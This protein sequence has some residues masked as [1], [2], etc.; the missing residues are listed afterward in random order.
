MDPVP[1]GGREARAQGSRP[2]VGRG[3]SSD[4]EAEAAVLGVSVHR[5][6]QRG[7]T[8]DP[9]QPRRLSGDRLSAPC[10]PRSPSQRPPNHGAGPRAVDAGGDLAR[11]VH[12]HRPSRGGAGGRA[13]C[14]G[15]GHRDRG[16]HPGELPDRSH[17]GDR[18]QRLVPGV[19]GRWPRRN[20]DR[21]RARTT[22]RLSGA[23][24]HGRSRR[25]HRR[26][27]PAE[28][29]QRRARPRSI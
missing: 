14:R 24:D 27:R 20:R 2:H 28:H 12:P 17:H 1:G 22:G 9:R 13:R 19:H 10:A 8:D 21:R 7:R 11:W 5:G 16:Q 4:R 6:R 25:R 15:G 18:A 29:E 26:K 23:G 3:C